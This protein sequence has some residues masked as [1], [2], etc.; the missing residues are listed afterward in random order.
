[1]KKLNILIILLAAGCYQQ[2]DIQSQQL[3]ATKFLKDYSRTYTVPRD[4]RRYIPKKYEVN[5]DCLSYIYQVADWS[6]WSNGPPTTAGAGEQRTT[7]LLDKKLTDNY[8]VSFDF[9]INSYYEETTILFIEIGRYKW[10]IKANGVIIHI[11]NE[12]WAWLPVNPAI[13]DYTERTSITIGYQDDKIVIEA[14]G[15]IQPEPIPVLDRTQRGGTLTFGVRRDPIDAVS[16]HAT[17]F[18]LIVEKVVS[19]NC[20]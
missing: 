3:P 7:T 8:L 11:D 5:L 14:P 19:N 1:M 15:A 4:I 10:E 12:P 18:T 16:A 6:D 2:Q 9:L 17:V 20:Q 13:A